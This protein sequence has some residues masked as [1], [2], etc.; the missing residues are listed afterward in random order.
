VTFLPIVERELRVAARRH[1][2]YS[3]RLV[4]ALAGIGVCVF[5][6]SLNLGAS[7]RLLGR[8]TFQGLSSLALGYCLFAGRR[9]TADCLTEEK[10]EG[11]L[12]L[13]FLTDLKGYD[14]VLGKL[15]ATSLNGFYSLFAIFPVLALPLLMGG[16]TNG[17]FWRMVLVLLD[18]FL[19]S[20]AAGVCASALSRVSRQA[21]AVNLLLILL[22]AASLPACAGIIAYFS[23][24]HW[25]VHALLVP[26]PVYCC[27]L[28]FDANYPW[29]E[30][31]FWCSIVVIHAF[32][33]L[34]VAVASWL[35][36]R[37]WRERTSTADSTNRWRERWQE[38][39]YG[40]A[41]QRKAF[42]TR[43]LDV[44]PFY[45]LAARV[46]SKPAGVW[47]FL[48]FIACWWLAMC[49]ALNFHWYDES[50]SITTGLMLGSVLKLWIALEAGQRLAEDRKI[51]ALELLLSTPL[52]VSEILRG[53]VLA[54]RR[55]FLKPCILAIG[56][57]WILFVAVGPESFQEKP[58]LHAFGIA[59]VFMFVTDV[60]ALIGVAMA[61]ALSVRNPN[62]TSLRTIFRVLILPS[63]AFLAIAI[64]VA[65][66]SGSERPGWRFYLLLWF[67]LG[68]LADLAFG[69]PAWNQLRTRFRSLALRGI[70]PTSTRGH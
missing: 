26:C 29:H 62:H 44:N 52:R 55:Q 40:N 27:Y 59:G 63:I 65:T 51:G 17:E 25:I 11:T 39:A 47:A 12:G 7:V 42:R 48:G 45:W 6:Y 19:F 20:L 38:W 14:V 58:R 24:S 66:G 5:F 43:L 8:Y 21:M 57:T 9:W 16:V 18:S 64:L 23:S 49:L 61:S 56:V 10:R 68:I 15:A 35:V 34:L 53:Q 36:P 50:L 31:Y 4:V 1:N 28:A 60:L 30:W 37:S 33:W 67:A 46:R 70:T 22:L 41:L 54:L 32:T 2:T 13:L 69:V 3:T